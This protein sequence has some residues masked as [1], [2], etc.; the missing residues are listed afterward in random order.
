M[1]KKKTALLLSAALAGV[2]TISLCA[3][4]LFEGD[5]VFDNKTPY[6]IAT[7][8]GYDGSP[9]SYLASVI[10]VGSGGDSQVRIAYEEAKKGGYTG[11]FLDFLQTYLSLSVN[12]SA[13]I[14][15]ALTSVVSIRCGFQES[16]GGYRPSSNTQSVTSA[17]SGVIY[18]LEKEN[19]NAYVITNYHVVYNA[20]SVG[21]ET[22]AHV[23]DN[24][25][26]YLYGG[27]LSSGAIRATYLGGAMNY[28]IAVLKVE[29]SE[30]L[31]QS[32]ARAVVSA[33]SDAVTVGEAAY[34][35]GNPE[36][37]GISVSGGIVSVDAEYIEIKSSDESTTLT[38]LEMRTDAPVNH[39]NS[40]GGLFNADGKL[41]GIVNAKTEE[42][43][44]EGLGY[45]IPANLA[46]SVAQNIIDNAQ[47]KGA[48]RATLG[49]SVGT[50][51]SKC[52][53]DEALGKAYIMETVAIT[54]VSDGSVAEGKLKAGDTLYSATLNGAETV[55]TRHH[56]LTSVLFNVRK[57]QTLTLKVYRGGQLISVEIAFDASSYF[58]LFN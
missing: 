2:M 24:I 18:S 32:S 17:G 10:G 35:I 1:K 37:E 14:N 48:V 41:I 25:S 4:D 57:D 34:A 20:D 21:T 30:V 23:S 42:D 9:E 8:Q 45:A 33:N 7:E 27:E 29:G 3:C 39:G 44:V 49:I 5:P 28:D 6:E 15:R 50:T 11:T 40:G 56:M 38:M 52:V 53:Y 19:G 54:S 58:T 43:G 16:L 36:G 22:T 46:L 55:I 13:N 51:G 26:L 47:S 31:K 12:D